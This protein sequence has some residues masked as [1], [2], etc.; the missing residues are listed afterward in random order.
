VPSASRP[1]RLHE[2]RPGHRAFRSIEAIKQKKY[3]PFALIPYATESRCEQFLEAFKRSKVF[4]LV[5][6]IEIGTSRIAQPGAQY[7][8]SAKNQP[9]GHSPAAKASSIMP[10]TSLWLASRKER[11]SYTQTMEVPSALKEDEI[12]GG[13][14]EPLTQAKSSIGHHKKST[15]GRRQQ[16][17][18]AS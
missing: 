7:P 6:V 10:G 13:S 3:K 1:S 5:S 8:G 16:N 4:G 9:P 11:K 2:S 15:G 12:S 14:T 17:Q 18:S